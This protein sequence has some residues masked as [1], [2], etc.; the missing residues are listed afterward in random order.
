MRPSAESPRARGVKREPQRAPQRG[1]QRKPQEYERA[2]GAQKELGLS[3]YW[4]RGCTEL[5]SQKTE[6]GA[7]NAE[8]GA[9]NQNT[10]ELSAQKTMLNP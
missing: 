1:S 7:Q 4:G 5:S 2:L 6:I 10:T 8:L 9:Q 3:Y